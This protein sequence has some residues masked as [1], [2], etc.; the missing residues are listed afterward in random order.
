VIF[1]G[2]NALLYEDS[3]SDL[4][5]VFFRVEKDIPLEEQIYLNTKV[6]LFDLSQNTTISI[7]NRGY[8]F[9]IFGNIF[10]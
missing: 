6:S 1:A 8:Y 4:T 10:Q 9:K 2:G 5:N 3:N 7:D